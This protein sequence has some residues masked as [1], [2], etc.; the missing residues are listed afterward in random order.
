[1]E[2]CQ[3]CGHVIFW[4][5]VACNWKYFNIQNKFHFE[6]RGWKVKQ[7]KE[8]PKIGNKNPRNKWRAS[9]AEAFRRWNGGRCFFYGRS[10]AACGGAGGHAAPN[11]KR[12][13]AGDVL[14]WITIPAQHPSSSG[15][16]I[17]LTSP[18]FF[19]YTH[20]HTHTHTLTYI[21]IYRK[22]VIP[23]DHITPPPPLS[24]SLSPE[25]RY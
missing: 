7:K 22:N 2:T 4:N 25:K 9:R 23:S 21:Y 13:T 18:G 8:S 17:F 3:R 10:D 14:P 19:V 11:N 16:N 15:S 1:M 20:T 24:L 12:R 5:G 6:I